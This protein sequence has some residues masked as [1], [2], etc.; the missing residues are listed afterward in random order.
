MDPTGI[1]SVILT[2]IGLI[3]AWFQIDHRFKRKKKLEKIPTDVLARVLKTKVLRIGWF[4]YPPFIEFNSDNSKKPKGLYPLILKKVSEKFNLKIEWTQINI[5]DCIGMIENDKVDIVISIFQTAKR[6]KKTDFTCFLHS[7]TVGGVTKKSIKDVNSL[8]DL[9]NS[10][11]KI[12]VSKGEIGHELIDTLDI[13]NSRITIINTDNISKIL[14]FLR[15]GDAEIALLDSVSIKNYFTKTADSYLKSLK[16]IFVNRP[17]EI[18][19]MGTM[20][21]I[22]QKKLSDWIEGEFRIAR[23]DKKIQLV[24]SE[25]IENYKELV[26]KF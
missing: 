3:F 18:C 14:S 20:I 15:S 6:A 4:D 7:I 21:P 25:I 16:Q 12:V 17:L 1:I 8:T 10:N 24:E 2:F 9:L 23:N 26:S 19:H 5:G 22:G 11:Y 13:R